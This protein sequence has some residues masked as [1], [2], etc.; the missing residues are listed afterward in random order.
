MN[1]KPRK[2]SDS[3]R[4]GR[5]S[6]L[7]ISLTD[8]GRFIF[9]NLEQLV[10]RRERIADTITFVDLL[11]VKVPQVLVVIDAEIFWWFDF[12]QF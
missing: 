8:R 9:V 1:E 11:L 7:L 6:S 4:R 5:K 2:L 10:R 3:H 12:F